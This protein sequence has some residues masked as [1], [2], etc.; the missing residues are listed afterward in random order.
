MCKKIIL[1]GLVLLLAGCSSANPVVSGS[2][3]ETA[4][5]AAGGT[6]TEETEEI[7]TEAPAVNVHEE[8]DRIVGEWF[9]YYLSAEDVSE[10]DSSIFSDQIDYQYYARGLGQDKDY[11]LSP[12]MWEVFYNEDININRDITGEDIYLIR[13][14]PEKLLELYAKNND[15][16]VEGICQELSTTKDVLYYNWG[17]DPCSVNYASKHKDN[18][19]AFSQKEIQIFGKVNFEERDTVMKT[20]M[21]TVKDG[22]AVYSSELEDYLDILRRDTLQA[23]TD[24]CNIYSQYSDIEK[25]GVYKVDGISIRTVI[26]LNMPNADMSVWEDEELIA[27]RGVTAFLNYS[28]FSYGCKSED[29]VNIMQYIEE[30]SE[31]E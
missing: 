14:D 29:K 2:A 18:K 19:V 27:D 23:F 13:L 28:P 5:T 25:N 30:V 21:I 12:D 7:A 26:P 3:E 10:K 16:T 31:D 4:V 17:Y 22:E 15:T 20:H 24:D 6:G 9:G 8:S 11:F 1:C